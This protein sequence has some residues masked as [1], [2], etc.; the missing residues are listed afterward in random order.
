MHC[1]RYQE[2]I[3]ALHDGELSDAETRELTEH[4]AACPACRLF[5]AEL[6]ATG[7]VLQSWDETPPALRPLPTS[8]EPTRSPLE[9]IVAHLLRGR[10]SI[11]V[12]AFGALLLLVLALLYWGRPAV[13]VGEQVQFADSDVVTQSLGE[14][15]DLIVF[16]GQ[17]A[18]LEPQGH[19]RR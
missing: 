5:Q 9:W 4:L 14:R 3:S 17:F 2:L 19:W 6:T 11:P 1:D 18:N 7:T 15:S 8:P 16:S 12:P 13:E 10:I